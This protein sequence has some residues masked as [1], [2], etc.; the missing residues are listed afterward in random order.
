MATANGGAV[1]DPEGDV[2]NTGRNIAT[3]PPIRTRQ[4]EPAPQP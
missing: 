4:R 3:P 1:F 2:E